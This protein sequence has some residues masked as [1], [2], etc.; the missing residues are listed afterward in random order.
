MEE[1]FRKV[2]VIMIVLDTSICKL[3]SQFTHFILR[4]FYRVGEDLLE[5]STAN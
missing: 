1:K 3:N 5:P 2:K 4:F